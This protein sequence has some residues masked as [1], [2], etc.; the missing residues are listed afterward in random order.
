MNALF[1]VSGVHY[2]YDGV[3]ALAGL[4]FTIARGRRV[5]LL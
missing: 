2:A 5:A 3:A 4:D 1:E